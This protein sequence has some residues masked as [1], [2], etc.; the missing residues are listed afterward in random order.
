M[1]KNLPS[2]KHWLPV[3]THLHKFK[4]SELLIQQSLRYLRSRLRGIPLLSRTGLLK[5]V[6]LSNS[7]CRYLEFKLSCN[8]E[9]LRLTFLQKSSSNWSP[10]SPFHHLAQKRV[11]TADLHSWRNT[12]LYEPT[13]IKI[14]R[15]HHDPPSQQTLQAHKQHYSRK[16]RILALFS[17]Y[18]C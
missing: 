11:H 16:E 9:S 1:L 4:M 3:S 14:E 17:E 18:A 13:P 12:F 15:Y 5:H 10:F 8:N 6:L 2:P 7:V